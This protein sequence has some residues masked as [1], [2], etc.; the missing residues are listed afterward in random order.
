MFSS[1]EDIGVN[2]CD[3]MTG[4]AARRMVSPVWHSNSLILIVGCDISKHLH[5]NEVC[6]YCTLGG[7]LPS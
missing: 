7:K 3:I 2:R 5:G 1:D 6:A 4:K